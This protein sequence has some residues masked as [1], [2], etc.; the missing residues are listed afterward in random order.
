MYSSAA[1]AEGPTVSLRCRHTAPAPTVVATAVSNA[2]PAAVAAATVAAATVSAA[3]GQRHVAA[4]A[5]TIASAWGSPPPILPSMVSC[6]AGPCR[7]GA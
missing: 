5:A 6:Q 4:T 7:Q 2:T 3:P 1:V